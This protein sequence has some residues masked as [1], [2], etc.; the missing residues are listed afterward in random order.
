MKKFLILLLLCLFN[1]VYAQS[2]FTYVGARLGLG[3]KEA[4]LMGVN[5]NFPSK[6]RNSYEIS[7]DY[8][9]WSKS[10]YEELQLGI[11]YKPEFYRNR[12]TSLRYRIGGAV[13]TDFYKFLAGPELGLEL[14]QAIYSGAEIIIANKNQYLFFAEKSYRLRTNLSIGLKISL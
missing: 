3:N 1:K 11:I 10:S 2:G 13:G 8:F 6:Y 5:L 4:R 14:G 9:Q 12:N 7:A